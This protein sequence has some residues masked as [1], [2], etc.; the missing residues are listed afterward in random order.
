MWVQTFISE[1]AVE[2]LHK[3]VLS[4]L[5]WLDKTLLGVAFFGPEKHRLAGEPEPLS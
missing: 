5:T 2:A 1:P 4:R 3:S